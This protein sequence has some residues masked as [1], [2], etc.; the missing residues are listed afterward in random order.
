MT[1]LADGNVGIGATDPTSSLDV[2]S[3]SLRLRT[4]LSW[5]LPTL[6][7][8]YGTMGYANDGSDW[9]FCVFTS[10]GWKTAVLS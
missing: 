4:A 3:D 10:S 8:E 1:I 9:R 5:P 7:T 6:S 2:N